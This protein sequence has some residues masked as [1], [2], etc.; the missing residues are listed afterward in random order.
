MSNVEFVETPSRAAG[1][2]LLTALALVGAM[3]VLAACDSGPSTGTGSETGGSGETS[4]LM[5]PHT[6][7]E[8]VMGAKDAPVTI[9]E[10]SSMTCPHCATFHNDTLPILKAKYIDTGKVRFIIRE[11]P[12]DNLAAA[13]F[14]L[15]RC[16]DK[17]KY[18]PFV[19]AL[20]ASQAKW[21]FTD[22]D[23]RPKLFD[24]AKQVGFNKE[25]FESCLTDQ[26][27]LDGINEIAKRGSEKF[28]V[29]STPT[30]FV[31]GKI[32][33]GAS[34]IRGFEEL[35]PKSVVAK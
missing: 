10:Y 13:A 19:D 17:D 28:G 2:R 5:K 4:E 7:P 23:P 3:F 29:N 22:G 8:N 30:F 1:K 33:K 27:L 20:Y 6:L 35:M 31:N 16:A 11:F 34:D 25:K 15:A 26:K 12:L 18:F 24:M 9:I 21:A 14:M 32:L